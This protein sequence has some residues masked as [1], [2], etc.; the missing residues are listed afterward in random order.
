MYP[1]SAAGSS[2]EDLIWHMAGR[3]K[4]DGNISPSRCGSD[5][6]RPKINGTPLDS[7]SLE[8]IAAAQMARH[9]KTNLSL[10]SS[11][12]CCHWWPS[13]K[14]ISRHF[15]TQDGRPSVQYRPL[16][17]TNRLM[18]DAIVESIRRSTPSGDRSDHLRSLI[19]LDRKTVNLQV[20]LQIEKLHLATC[21][22]L[23]RVE[24]LKSSSLP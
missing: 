1:R 22:Q 19:P 7:K 3:D 13:M 15:G 20:K 10:I 4:E 2:D 11:A 17:W 9:T 16:L 18:A 12:A 8:M 23:I 6:G 21:S 14:M 24:T 5:D